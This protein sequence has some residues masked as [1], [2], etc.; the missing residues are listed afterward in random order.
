MGALTSERAT[1][2]V[3]NLVLGV[4]PILGSWSQVAAKRI[5]TESRTA[6]ELS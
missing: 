5:R 6:D 1:V 3:A 4:Y 2:P